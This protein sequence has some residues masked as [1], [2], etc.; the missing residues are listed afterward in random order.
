MGV[1]SLLLEFFLK[2]RIDRQAGILYK[3]DKFLF[4]LQFMAYFSNVVSCEATNDLIAKNYGRT[5]YI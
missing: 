4:V 1:I 2:L 3:Q 5:L